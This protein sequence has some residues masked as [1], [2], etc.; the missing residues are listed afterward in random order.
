[1]AG[2]AHQFKKGNLAIYQTLLAKIEAN[3]KA[4]V[5]LDRAQWYRPDPAK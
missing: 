1:M 2:S 5:P 3:G 4:R